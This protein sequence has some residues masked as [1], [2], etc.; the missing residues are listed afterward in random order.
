MVEALYPVASI[1]LG[2]EVDED[3]LIGT[4]ENFVP[5]LPV[6]I[7]V[8][9][10]AKKPVSGIPAR[11]T[12]RESAR[13]PLHANSG[14]LGFSWL[15]RTA[16][17]GAVI[18][19]V[20]AVTWQQLRTRPVVSA[21]TSAPGIVRQSRAE[22]HSDD[23][24]AKEVA[25]AIVPSSISTGSRLNSQPQIANAGPGMVAPVPAISPS[26]PMASQLNAASGHTEQG[27]SR[28]EQD[29]T[30][31]SADVN[32]KMA[33]LAGRQNGSMAL[34]RMKISGPPQKL[35]YPVC[36]DSSTRGKVSLQAVVGYDGTVSQIRVLGGNRVLAAA[37]K[38]A[39]REWRYEPFS[40]NAQKLER[41]ARITIS[42]IS[43]DVVAVSFPDATLSR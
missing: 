20:A 14:T 18:V 40:A 42:F 33:E 41:E 16:S 7:Q 21:S 5:P 11:K 10:A 17:T 28:R 13:T 30:E 26:G 12:A 8:S 19:I 24:R 43:D 6:P 27:S 22:S 38:R 32:V 31:V 9:T 1:S 2:R 34:P 23:D 29:H 25:P 3:N 39:I 4:V 36:P 37:A 35:V 15:A